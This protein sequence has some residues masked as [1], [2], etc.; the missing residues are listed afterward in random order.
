[1]AGKLLTFIICAL[2]IFSASH[3]QTLKE[4]IDRGKEIYSGNCSSCHM[5]K[6]EGVEGTFPPLVKSSYVTGDTG[7]LINILLQGQ[8]GEI[9]VDGK[10]YS[11]DMPAQSHLSDEEI[12][13]V[14][15]FI[16]SSWGNKTKKAVLAADVKEKRSN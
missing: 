4:S 7:Q 13:D 14:L 12:A 15:N 8:S 3:A 11:M 6:G 1:M 5:E 9:T 10:S 16:R 2:A